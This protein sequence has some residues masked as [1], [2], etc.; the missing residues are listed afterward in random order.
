MSGVPILSLPRV[1]TPDLHEL[2]IMKHFFH[3][4]N[5]EWGLVSVKSRVAKL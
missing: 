1:K 4:K 3:I 5:D 2:G